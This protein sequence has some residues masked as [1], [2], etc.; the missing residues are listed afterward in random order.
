[1][2]IDDVSQSAATHAVSPVSGSTSSASVTRSAEAS[3]AAAGASDSATVSA[4]ASQLASGSDV[5]MEK[6]S[7]VQQALAAGT[8]HVS[9][10]D[11]ADSLIASMLKN[12]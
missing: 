6:V 12:S 11:L 4:G 2:K 1:M 5:R 8:Y 9:A 10:G 3:P 7:S